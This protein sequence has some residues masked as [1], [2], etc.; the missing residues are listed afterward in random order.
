MTDRDSPQARDLSSPPGEAHVVTPAPSLAAWPDDD[1]RSGEAE[2]HEDGVSGGLPD[3]S[4]M[5]A[6]IALI[7]AIVVGGVG[8]ALVA[9]VIGAVLGLNVSSSNLAPGL[10]ITATAIEELSFVGVAVI[11]AGLGGRRVRPA[12]F[13]LR[14]AAF[15]QA[16]GWIIVLNVSFIAVTAAW[17]AALNNHTKEKVLDTLGAGHGGLL[18]VASAILT[19]VVAPFCEEFLFRG[20]IFTA[21]RNWRGVW[22]AALITGLV[23]GLVHGASAPLVDLLPLAF[24]GFGLCLLYWRTGSLLPGIAAHSLNNSIAF[25]GILGWS[26]GDGLLLIVAALGNARPDRGPHAVGRADRRPAAR[27]AGRRVRRGGGCGA[28]ALAGAALRSRAAALGGAARRSRAAALGGAALRSRAAALGGAALRSRAA[29]LGGDPRWKFDRSS[30]MVEEDRSRFPSVVAQTPGSGASGPWRPDS[31]HRIAGMRQRHLPLLAALVAVALAPASSLAA[32]TTTTTSS[33]SATTTT[34]T[35]TTASTTTT[36]STTTSA[37]VNGRVR[38]ELLHGIGHPAFALVGHRLGVWGRVR[39]YVPD[40]HITVRF[41][42]DGRRVATQTAAV[43]N[44]GNGTGQFRLGF[45]SRHSGVLVATALHAATSTI[46]TFRLVAPAQIRVIDPNLGFGSSGPSVRA[47]QQGLS[48][49]HYAVPQTGVYDD[50]TDLAVI[51]FRKMTSDA[52]VDDTDAH[53]F[54][55]LANGDGQFRVRYPGDGKHVEADLSRQVLAEIDPG[56]HVH[57]IY[58]TSSGKPSTPTVIGRFHVYL[59]TPGTNSEGMVDSN[60]FVRG[61]AIHGYASVP[62]YAASHGCLR[63]PIPDAASVFGWVDVGNAV[64]VYYENGGG[65]SHVRGNAGP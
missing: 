42:V 28:A 54:E 7:A 56:G 18:L 41:S 58:T 36:T 33:S 30:L 6:A 5:S 25:A 4:P 26:F 12:Q 20:Y 31:S 32:T 35:T 61:Y 2:A 38:L 1:A 43:Q 3:W 15:W 17:T 29:A 11:V 46:G 44:L 63:I 50:L 27:R 59:K 9:I 65:S 40:L 55:Q 10:E 8:G 64:D 57:L 14:T 24:F 16:V 39:P 13:G 52:L 47:L 34:S 53:L 62:T 48:A 51:A 45:T 49:L 37:P 21:L 19:C 60:Y 22:P 23:F